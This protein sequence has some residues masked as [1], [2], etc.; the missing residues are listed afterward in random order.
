MTDPGRIKMKKESKI[1]NGVIELTRKGK[2]KWT[3]EE[4]GPVTRYSTVYKITDNKLINVHYHHH[5]NRK[6]DYIVF[7]YYDYN[8][9]IRKELKEVYPYNKLSPFAYIRLNAILKRLF[10]GII[11]S[12]PKKEGEVVQN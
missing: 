9:N 12:E 2:L 1:L 3:K 8:N 6:E 4:R 5:N 10:N 11:D 7:D